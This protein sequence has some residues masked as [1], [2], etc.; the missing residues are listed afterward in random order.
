MLG[1]DKG[2]MKLDMRQKIVESC[3]LYGEGYA[4]KENGAEH[5]HAKVGAANRT[6][7]LALAARPQG[8]KKATRFNSETWMPDMR[9]NILVS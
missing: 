9:K 6:W 5:E 3:A 2:S 8:F 7:P 4:H 1:Q